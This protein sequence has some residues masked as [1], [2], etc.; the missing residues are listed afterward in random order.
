MCPVGRF[1]EDGEHEHFAMA[2]ERPG[3]PYE[4]A[5]SVAFPIAVAEVGNLPIS[6][7]ARAFLIGLSSHKSVVSH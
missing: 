2:P 4:L 7:W 1:P 6:R 3:L 5:D